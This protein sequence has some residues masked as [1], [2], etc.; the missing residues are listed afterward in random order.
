MTKSEELNQRLARL[1]VSRQQSWEAVRD[2]QT[3]VRAGITKFENRRPRW[4]KPKPPQPQITPAPTTPTPWYERI[5][6][7]IWNSLPILIGAVLGLLLADW[8]GAW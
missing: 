7:R 1:A 8:L 2:V 5:P 4:V 6:T 3:F